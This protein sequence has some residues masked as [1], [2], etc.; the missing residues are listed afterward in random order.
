MTAAA[1]ATQHGAEQHNL[2]GWQGK[3]MPQL[4]QIQ[5]VPTF[6]L[7]VKATTQRLLPKMTEQAKMPMTTNPI[8]DTHLI[9]HYFHSPM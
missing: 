5:R 3:T 6:P 4:H 2:P 9:L 1:F 7:P 8:A